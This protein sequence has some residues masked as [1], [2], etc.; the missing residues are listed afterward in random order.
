MAAAGG[1]TAEGFDPGGVCPKDPQGTAAR[2]KTT[3]KPMA[4]RLFAMRYKKDPIFQY[5]IVVSEA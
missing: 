5:S 3:V 4:R 2:K 1:G